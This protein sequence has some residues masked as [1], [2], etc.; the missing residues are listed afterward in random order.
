[1]IDI[2][3]IREK[4]DEVK[5]N[6]K[7]RNNPDYITW[8]DQVIALDRHIRELKGETDSL[9]AR[10]NKVSAEINAAQKSGG[11]TK[12]LI[13]EA[14]DIPR[15][16]ADN[17]VK[18]SDLEAKYR[19][20]MLRIPN[21]LHDSVPEGKTEADNK[22]V[23]EYG[24]KV[25]HDFEPVSH[26]DLMSTGDL[27]DLD[28]AAKISGAR[29]YFLK[30][31]FARLQLALMEYAVD[32]MTKKEAIS[33]SPELFWCN[34]FLFTA[35]DYDHKDIIIKELEGIKH[36]SEVFYADCKEFQEHA[37]WNGYSIE[38]HNVT[39]NPVYE[40][41]TKFLGENK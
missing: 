8:I 4:T 38:V 9:R 5:A 41:L 32:F 40:T 24:T 15:K 39:G 33:S 28:R 13:E 22:V 34:G 27:V 3:Q 23:K 1:M 16:I 19:Y 7:R 18:M 26:I 20:F 35:Y 31:K 21:L 17:D 14:K 36:F 37:K 11:N 25:K 6:L 30:G 29:W 12:S 2:K 10:R